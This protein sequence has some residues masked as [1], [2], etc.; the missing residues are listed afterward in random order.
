MLLHR[1]IAD[2]PAVLAL[3]IALD[4]TRPITLAEFSPD[5]IEAIDAV[6]A[7]PAAIQRLR[8]ATAPV[9]AMVSVD[10]KQLGAA[11]L[12]AEV[13]RGQHLVVARAPL[14]RA[15]VV[16]V[17]VDA[18]ARAIDLA[19]DR[20]DDAAQ[21][22]IG[23]VPGLADRAEQ[24]LVDAALELAELD[25]VVVAAV[26]DRRGGPT[27]VVQRCAGAPARCT[28][29]A[30]VG[31][32]DRAGLAGAAREAWQAVKAGELRTGPTVLGD[33]RPPVVAS[34]CRLCRNP[35][36][37]AGAAALVVGAVVAIVVASGSKPPPIVVVDGHGF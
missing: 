8:I 19:L 36:V 20:D 16:G 4:P 6:R 25:E 3:A 12:D 5:V 24:Q 13:T 17:Y 37:W 14:H 29:A 28:A 1:R 26:S 32:G 10:G 11:P 22:A 18:A 23:A 35:L 21:L 2:A 27:L 9:G 30:E 31:F 15:T 33:S 7:A 34:G